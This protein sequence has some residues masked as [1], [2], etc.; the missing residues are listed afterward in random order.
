MAHG[1]KTGGR[2]KGT[3]NRATVEKEQFVAEVVSSAKTDGISPL[4]YMLQVMRD[5]T[6]DAVRRLDAAKSAAPFVHPRLS[7][8]AVTHDTRNLD[9]LDTPALVAL[10]ASGRGC[11]STE[12]EEGEGGDNPVY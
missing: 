1:K 2:R 6:E 4:E 5:P 11:C 9:D 8:T 12:A 7:A 3:K 10:L